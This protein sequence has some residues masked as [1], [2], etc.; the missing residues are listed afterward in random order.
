MRPRV[1]GKWSSAMK[2]WEEKVIKIALVEPTG[3]PVTAI[4][5]S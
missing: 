5:E 4:T 2:Q 1:R 3:A